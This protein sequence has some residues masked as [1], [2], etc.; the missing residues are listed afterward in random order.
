MHDASK[1]RGTKSEC[2]VRVQSREC[3]STAESARMQSREC[4]ECEN[5]KLRVKSQ[6]CRESLCSPHCT[7]MC[8]SLGNARDSATTQRASCAT[9]GLWVRA[10]GRYGWQSMRSTTEERGVNT[11][12]RVARGGRNKHLH[13]FRFYTHL[14]S[15]PRRPAEEV[16]GAEGSFLET[17]IPSYCRSPQEKVQCQTWSELNLFPV[18]AVVA[19]RIN[20]LRWRS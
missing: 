8:S 2:N 19:D 1:V 7:L 20:E 15:A 3:E 16:S 12:G 5:A 14:T 18:P 10:G 9:R 13:N 4:R 11:R 6:E 17:R